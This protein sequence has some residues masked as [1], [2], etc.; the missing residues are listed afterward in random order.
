LNPA[1][2]RFRLEGNNL[3]LMQ[4]DNSGF[5][6]AFGVT[7]M[8]KMRVETIAGVGGAYKLRVWEQGQTEPST[9]LLQ[10][11]GAMSD[12]Q[13]GCFA[14]LSHH[15]N[16][17][18]GNVT[19]TSLSNAFVTASV[20]TFLEGPFS[21]SNTSM[22][23]SLRPLLP[24]SQPYNAA[25][26]NYSGTETVSALP[27]D[28]VDWVMVELRTGASS[29]TTVSRRAAFIKN[30]GMIVDLDGASAVTFNSISPGNYYIVVRHRN[31]L[32][33]MTSSAQSLGTSATTYDFA[34]A[35]SQA[36]GSMPMAQ[37]AAGVFGMYVG[38]VNASGIVS[39]ADANNIFGVLNANIYNVNDANLSGIVTAADANLV[40]W[41]LNR[42]TQVP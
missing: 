42:A 17:E 38:D 14:L 36:Y 16:A 3:N 2:K 40:M 7:Y 30:H 27:A 34:T 12:P 21:S 9:W 24:L 5:H 6:M 4:Q 26:W 25:P 37:L 8:F 29:A 28:V 23:T 18:F 10:G 31:H 39:S 19:V 1:E 35:Q 33:I 13:T 41:N 22:T 20:K 32:A 15:V 11:Q